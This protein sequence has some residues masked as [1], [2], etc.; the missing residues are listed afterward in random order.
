MAFR[1]ATASVPC[2]MSDASA[3]LRDSRLTACAASAE[4]AWL[5][6]EDA[7]RVLWAN[8]AA[9]QLLGCDTVADL[10]G[11]SFTA[12]DRTASQVARLAASLAPGGAP[13]LERL[14]GFG[15][16]FLR[17]L[18]ASCARIALADGTQGIFI[19][20]AEPTGR[21]MPLPER[22]RR[23]FE[24]TVDAIAAFTPEGALMYATAPARQ[25]M[26]NATTL[27]AFNASALALDALNTGAASG[28][29]LAG[30]VSMVR[31]GHAADTLL[32]AQFG[33]P[34]ADAV[35]GAAAEAAVGPAPAVAP[36][37][38][39][40][41][42]PAAGD[43]HAEAK[44]ETETE[45]EASVATESTA[46]PV[47]PVVEAPP[48]P[49]ASSIAEAAITP[50]P[51]AAE[52]APRTEH[53]HPL[54]FVWQMNAENRFT[55]ASDEILSI[56]GP[57]M[58]GV[59]GRTWDEINAA[60]RLDPAG[61]VARAIATRDTWSGLT[62][63]WPADGS[64]LR[65]KFELSGLPIYDRQRVFAG[66]RGFGVCR[67]LDTVE[68]ILRQRREGGH[69]PDVTPQASP[70]PAA[71][72]PQPEPPAERAA[73]EF[74]PA[75]N[76]VPFRIA[77]PSTPEP[78]QAGSQAGSSAGLDAGERNAFSEIARQLSAR[79]KSNE[80]PEPLPGDADS[81]ARI[82]RNAPGPGIDGRASSTAEELEQAAAREAALPDGKPAWL[83]KGSDAQALL[84][85]LPLGVLIYRFDTLF[86]ANKPFLE[87]VGYDSLPAFV[88]AGGLDSL[89]IEA[90][91]QSG[92]A[93]S[94]TLT[95]TTGKGDKVPVEGRL[96]SIPWNGE[97]ALALVLVGPKQEAAPETAPPEKAEPAAFDERDRARI[98][99][100]EFSIAEAN[101]IAA[102][103]AAERAALLAKVTEQ[104]RGPLSGA[105]ETIDTILSERFGPIGNERYRTLLSDIR[106]SGA[107]ILAL[108]EDLASLSKVD[109][110]KAEPSHG[111]GVDLNELVQ[112]SV[113]RMQPEA[114]RVRVLI[115]TSL[116][117]A[118]APVAA[119]TDSL[120][121]IVGNLLANSI[122]FA[123]TGGQVI[124]ST[125][126]GANGKVV[127][128]LRDTGIGLDA[129][130]L[131]ALQATGTPDSADAADQKLSMTIT[132]A[133][134]AA[135]NASLSVSS[136]RDDGTM[137]EV[138]FAAARG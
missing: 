25:R 55:L 49:P 47:P 34:H 35:L 9:A 133:M 24:G 70:P 60:L 89:F 74:T 103:A 43:V 50:P 21:S 17:P 75:Q 128:R 113:T 11:H 91:G 136:R 114:S 105:V 71:E 99:E 107:R 64:D 44:T 59:L 95:I 38:E 84:D 122:R 125:A 16:G 22:A 80:R 63:R 54:R 15:T 126:P 106:G 8:A 58:A 19:L 90:E 94:Q 134:V 5:W 102:E 116:A 6:S 82:L 7:T 117:T 28:E 57:E 129:E 72:K 79:L 127:L 78:R 65:L 131:A 37:A 67:D 61:E 69:R 20:G 92:A 108:F 123:G 115:R 112:A 86:Y 119:E 41:S 137:I 2:L 97:S 66:Y 31:I 120:R 111:P 100:L 29:T 62:I 109:G 93:A 42:A 12:G 132:R 23:L 73:P 76:V 36:P 4:P 85:R 33:A 77:Q 98:A 104:V 81:A 88:E 52:A 18:T 45:T 118:L 96:F 130:E 10:T 3:F 46:T 124:V 39:E 27:V 53:Q 101:R 83:A 48:V 56:I 30:A 68:A 51:A 32:V 26:A 87:R 40:G 121:Q 110:V 138:V 1:L 13:R 14:R 135:N